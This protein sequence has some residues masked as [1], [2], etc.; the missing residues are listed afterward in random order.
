MF[1]A[2]ADRESTVYAACGA[3]SPS[4]CRSF[5]PRAPS[6]GIEGFDHYHQLALTSQRAS[7]SHDG[8]PVGLCVL[9]GGVLSLFAIIRRFRS[10][11]R[12]CS[13]AGAAARLQLATHWVDRRTAISPALLTGLLSS[14]H[15]LRVDAVVRPVCTVIFLAAVLAFVPRW[16]R[17]IA[18]LRAVGL[19]ARLAR[20]SVQ[21]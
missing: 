13:R 11:R 10:P 12:R 4:D 1:R 20:S 21:T 19:F 18:H 7:V 3:H 17:C 9:P 2:H 8:R 16:R 14:Q 6:W 5:H 15:G